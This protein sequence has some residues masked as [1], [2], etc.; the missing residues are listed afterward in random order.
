MAYRSSWVLAALFICLSA[1][2]ADDKDDFFDAARKGDAARVRA[3]LARG[4]DVNAAWRYE[5]TALLMAARRGSAEVVR[6]LL[7][8]GART[9][10]KDTFYGM[11][12]VSSAAGEGHV[13]IV[14]M[15]LE[16]GAPGRDDA[17]AIAASN[18]NL[19]MVKTILSFGGLQ[20]EA[21]SQALTSA[22]RADRK[23]LAEVLKAAGAVPAPEPKFQ[24]DPSTLRKYSGTYRD[25][26][27]NEFV[28]LVKEG[29]LFGG[30]PGQSI[31]LGAFDELTFQPL[32]FPGIMITFLVEAGKVTGVTIK[33]GRSTQSYTRVEVK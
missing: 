2:R 20:P 21:L 16:K 24:V 18:G 10:V 33:Q 14:K 30:P 19:E 3:L 31:A 25:A 28:F 5:T 12:P 9:D 29:R 1:G 11:T 26:R 27:E 32:Q 17:L 7:D 23:E 13:E 8:N 4:V 15:L 22:L 6:I